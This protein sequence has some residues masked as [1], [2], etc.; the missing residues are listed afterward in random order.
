MVP[1]AALARAVSLVLSKHRITSRHPIHE[2]VPLLARRPSPQRATP[3]GRVTA[4]HDPDGPRPPEA[5]ADDGGDGEASHGQQHPVA[6]HP[7]DGLGVL[8]VPAVPLDDVEEAPAVAL[9]VAGHQDADALR[10]LAGD[11]DVLLPDDGQEEGA[12]AVHDG[13]VG[14]A[15]VAA[16]GL[17]GLDDAQE[18][19]VLG[20]GAHGVVADARGDGEA[21]PGGVAQER[22][23]TA[24]A[25]I[26]KVNVDAAV[27]GEHEVAD[28]IGALD[29]ERVVVEGLEE[30]GVLGGDEGAGLFIGPE[31]VDVR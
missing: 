18:E 8:P 2:F 29:G 24:V 11:A 10:G 6:A 31:L 15:P 1:C 27:V 22:V 13:D 16:V 23:K 20:D 26:V 4:P 21:Q 14:H 5:A 30:P 12:G 3:G 17:E 19:G 7:E 25:A 28:G 9:V